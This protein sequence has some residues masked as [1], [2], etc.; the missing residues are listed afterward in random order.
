MSHEGQMN[1]LVEI[2]DK[3]YDKNLV[4]YGF[5][6]NNLIMYHQILKK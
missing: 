4:F 5:I 2:L 3:R 1:L 6:L